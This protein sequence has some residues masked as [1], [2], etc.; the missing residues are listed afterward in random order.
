[1]GKPFKAAL[2]LAFMPDAYGWRYGNW[3]R[4]CWRRAN[5]P[6][7]HRCHGIWEWNDG[8]AESRRVR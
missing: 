8:D 6:G 2:C 5:H 1:M 7:P 3:W 4:S